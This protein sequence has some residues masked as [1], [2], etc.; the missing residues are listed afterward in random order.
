M[1]KGLFVTIISF[2]LLAVSQLYAQ[3]N[4]LSPS[5]GTWCN[6]QMLVI[7][8]DSAGDYFYSVDGSDP[9]SFGFAYD[10]PVLLDME[11][12]V[13]LKIAKIISRNK[14]EYSE[15]NFTVDADDAALSNYADFISS[16]Y[17]AGNLNYTAGTDL[18]IPASLSYS[19]GTGPEA[20]VKGRTVSLSEKSV[21]SRS[22]PCTVWDQA[23]NKKWRFVINTF[24]VSAGSFSRRDLPV[25]ITD[26]ETVE[27][28]DNNLIYKIDSEYWGLPKQGVKLDRSVSHMISWQ[29]IDF[30][31]GNP[32]EFII[33]P[34]KPEVKSTV[35]ES[36]DLVI[37]VNG[38]ESYRLAVLDEKNIYTE[39]FKEMGIDVFYGDQISGVLKAGIFSSGLLQG[40]VDIPYALNKRPPVAPIIK[41]NTDSFYTRSNV[42]LS[43]T[44]CGIGNLYYAVSEPLPVDEKRR[45]PTSPE[46]TNVTADNFVMV[47]GNSVNITLTGLKESGVYYK[48]RAYSASGTNK[49]EIAEY[50]IVIDQYNYY[51]DASS[52]FEGQDGTAQKPYSSFTELFKNINSSR[53]V[54]LRIS[55]DMVV[56][57]G[58]YILSSNCQI[59]GSE[60]ASITFESG[61]QLVVVDSTLEVNGLNIKNAKTDSEIKIVPLIKGERSN[62]IFTDCLLYS[63]FDKNG[64]ILDAVNSNVYLTK[65]ICAVSCATYASFI[66]GVN[67]RLSVKDS[68]LNASADTCVLISLNEGTVNCQNSTFKVTGKTGRIAELFN[69]SGL[70]Q[71]NV[72]KGELSKVSKSIVP[73]FTENNSSVMLSNNE[74][75]GF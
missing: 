41:G 27:F 60:N 46:F 67:S 63:D 22:I 1:K 64:T 73:V 57:K 31:Q 40:T 50:G 75:Y 23:Q 69:V 59:T 21:I 17:D 14:A 16:F 7:N 29:N 45:L 4:V 18:V 11:G 10:G 30:K 28:I 58:K 54:S 3:I 47:N 36:G 43:I 15:I 42:N 35:T 39:L 20:F 5:E 37:S 48:V 51:F 68:N 13:T 6:K 34:A 25:K 55:G 72:F 61:A 12:N 19:L 65:C 74:N 8:T 49:S 26:W 32:V 9:A 52:G 70:M 71:N 62:L 56:P 38:D 44:G 66:S 33:L 24:P 53:S 2:M